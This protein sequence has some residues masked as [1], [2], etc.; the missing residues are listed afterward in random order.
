MDFSKTSLARFAV[1]L[2]MSTYALIDFNRSVKITSEGHQKTTIPSLESSNR[3]VV[4]ALL[5]EQLL[6]TPDACSSNPVIG[7]FYVPRT[8]VTVNC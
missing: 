4:V 8:F 7:G 1:S 5:A 2:I 3:A 6:P